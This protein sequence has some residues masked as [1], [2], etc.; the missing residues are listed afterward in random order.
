MP[1]K[2]PESIEVKTDPIWSCGTCHFY[3]PVTI[4]KG[5]CLGVPP[6]PV[7]DE[8]GDLFG[9]NVPT[10]SDRRGCRFWKPRHNA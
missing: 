2:K 7:V 3:E 8:D 10:S 9:A 5:Y 4:E 1:R 6:H